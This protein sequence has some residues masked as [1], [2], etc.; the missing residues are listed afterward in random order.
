MPVRALILLSV[1]PMFVLPAI[2]ADAQEAGQ[3]VD[4]GQLDPKHPDFVRCRKMPVPGSTFQKKRVCKA[5]RDRQKDMEEARGQADDMAA[6]A[7]N[8]RKDCYG[9]GVYC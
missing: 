1:L 3:V 4:N 9:G 7:R 8:S 5:N 2:P 6:Q